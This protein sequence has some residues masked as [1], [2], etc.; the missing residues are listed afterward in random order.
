[1][2]LFLGIL[3]FLFVFQTHA[4]ERRYH[5][6]GRVII[7]GGQ[8][9]CEIQNNTNDTGVIHKIRYA[10]ECSSGRNGRPNHYVDYFRCGEDYENCEIAGN[11]FDMLPGPDLP[12]CHIQ[13]ASCYFTYS[14]II[15]E[16]DDDDDDD[17]WLN[18]N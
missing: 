2:K 4:S 5:N 14:F 16:D 18:A 13:R 11:D 6:Y 8:L 3:S 17:E 12:R 9:A 1:M 7:N 10:Y 15:D